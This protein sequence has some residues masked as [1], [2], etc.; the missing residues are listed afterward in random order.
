MTVYRFNHS[1]PKSRSPFVQQSAA[2]LAAEARFRTDFDKLLRAPLRRDRPAESAFGGL[3]KRRAEH[4]AVKA[5]LAKMD[6]QLADLNHLLNVVEKSYAASS[7]ARCG[8]FAPMRDDRLERM[9]EALRALPP[10]EL[11]KLAQVN[12]EL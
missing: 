4:Q 7:V 3:A 12:R 11:A 9:G 1:T 5:E 6:R 8:T 10:A 2:D